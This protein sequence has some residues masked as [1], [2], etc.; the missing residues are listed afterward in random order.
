MHN[1]LKVNTPMSN[2]IKTKHKI[3]KIKVQNVG[4]CLAKTNTI[5]P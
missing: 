2:Y 3:V 5:K 1:K 4:N